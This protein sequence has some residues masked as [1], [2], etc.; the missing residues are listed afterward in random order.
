MSN[1]GPMV[2]WFWFCH[3]LAQFWLSKKFLYSRQTV[4]V[5]I[6][7][8]VLRHLILVCIVF[9]GPIYGNIDVKGFWSTCRKMKFGI[10]F[11]SFAYLQN[12]LIFLELVKRCFAYRNDPKLSDSGYMVCLLFCFF[13]I[14]CD[15]V[16]RSFTLFCDWWTRLP[17]KL[18]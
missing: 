14:G 3:V 4:R 8:C 18:R 15:C 12:F 10:D 6:R 16:H 5:P 1:T 7:H 9:Q 17:I 13:W 11:L 2:L